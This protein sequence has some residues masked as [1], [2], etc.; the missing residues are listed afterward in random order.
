MK[1]EQFD[2]T[3]KEG[4]LKFIRASLRLSQNELAKTLGVSEITV[5]RWELGKTELPQMVA[6]ALKALYNVNPDWL[7][8]GEG[9]P[10]LKPQ[11]GTVKKK[12][13][14]PM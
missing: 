5:R 14:L 9:E 10:F 4:R 11:T 13:K 7:L 1:K 12:T 6:Y 2:L 3:T 8:T